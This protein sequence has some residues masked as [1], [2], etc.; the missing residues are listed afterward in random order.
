MYRKSLSSGILIGFL[1]VVVMSF[2]VYDQL[3]GLLPGWR[4]MDVPWIPRDLLRSFSQNAAAF[5]LL[6]VGTLAA[7]RAR[8]ATLKDGIR[9]GALSGLVVAWM[10]ETFLIAPYNVIRLG[11]AF[12]VVILA[13]PPGE[14]VF[15]EMLRSAIGN[16]FRTS[17]VSAIVIPLLGLLLG[18]VEGFIVALVRRAGGRP[19]A[20]GTAGPDLLDLVY[21]PR[22][23][24]LP[25]LQERPLRAGLVGGAIGGFL[26]SAEVFILAVPALLSNGGDF[27]LRQG[28]LPTRLSIL[29]ETLLIPALILVP[30]TILLWGGFGVL[31]L[32]HP[33]DRFASRFRASLA[34]GA[35]GGAIFALLAVVPVANMLLMVAPLAISGNT[36]TPLTAYAVE[37]FG[38]LL[39]LG[40]PLIPIVAVLA[41]T[42][43]GLV[44]G[45]PWVLLSALLWPRRPVDRAA[46]L[47][48][49]LRRHPE[50]LLPSIYALFQR[51]G[52]AIRV[53][54]HAVPRLHRGRDQAAAVVVAAYHTL[55]QNPGR[56][57]DSLGV[58]VEATAANPGWRWQSEIGE[59][60]RFLREGLQARN[61]YHMAAIRLLPEEHTSSLPQVLTL[62]GER[63]SR[64]V[65]ELKKAQRVDDPNGRSIYLNR[66]MEEITAAERYIGESPEAC[67]LSGATPYP[68]QQILCTLLPRWRG[69][70]LESLR[71]LR[72]RALLQAELETRQFTFLPRLTLRL[73]VANTG[74]NVAEQVRITLE[75]GGGYQLLPESEAR[76]ELLPPGEQRVVDLALEPRA[77]RATRVLFHI[78]YNDAVD[79]N[80]ELTL[81][82]EIV[83]AAA[84]RPFQRIFP[85]PY[86]T[87]TPIKTQEMFFGRQDVF[88]YIREHLLGTYQNNI[89]VLHGQRRTGKT[90]VLY[91]L[92][93]VLQD[94]HYCVLLDMQGI[95]ARSEAEFFYTVSDEIAYALE[96]AGLE[97]TLPPR[98]EYESQPEFTFRSRFL[99][100]LYPALGEKHLLLMFDEFEELQRHV[101]EGH[102]GAG[103]FPFLRTIMQHERPVDFI[104]S[105]THKLED[106]AA[107][108]WS[109]L[110][111]IATYKQISFLERQEVERLIAEPVAPF[112]MEYDP[113]A[114][115]RIY[116]VTAG[117]PFLTQ[118][119]CHEMVAYH[120]ETER[121][122]I[123]V[124][125][126]DSVL[127]RIAERG[128][129]HFKYVWAGA[130]SPERL[131]MLALAEL[132][133][134]TEAA[135]AAEIAALTQN[136]QQTIDAE[137]AR[138]ALVRLESRDIVART[139]PGSER[140]RFRVDLVRRWVARNPQLLDTVSREE[141]K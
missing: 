65:G 82:D 62:V 126:V 8:P 109:I 45:L 18:A 120:N 103:I 43:L 87:G 63:L 44:T 80:R 20:A 88:S 15:Q 70:L 56:A 134:H 79:A 19:T 6:F 130:D 14:T 35:V 22:L 27:L 1:L 113:L 52:Q 95:A 129:A 36:G 121:S 93:D 30:L 72:G 40:Y 108:Y 7:L 84:E 124:A 91:R 73:R 83:F 13:A 11:G 37:A 78:Y 49:R 48:R 12:Y 89:I 34:C 135:T 61:F 114:V 101:E 39:S 16:V 53:L 102:I 66:A 141:P 3:T 92:G 64:A 105:G 28:V 118:L 107:E 50:T 29:A 86:V 17:V 33:P 51:D 119:V 69:A 41:M 32:T 21:H 137:T 24:R 2:A 42:L 81:A 54:E 55:C 5:L 60:H 125:D 99:R 47:A 98:Q 112:G 68:E 127:E 4:W 106:L 76:I 9:V 104:F 136:R 74:L 97:V 23:P 140:F 94:T 46:A 57:A 131:T 59:L 25:D 111:N 26:L 71:D 38:H 128:E 90:S 85:I 139:A 75:P 133:T 10:V 132:L 115:Q 58:I 117:H 100:G 77:P 122:Y 31:F 110:F 67:K 138:R 116:E 96:K 123:S